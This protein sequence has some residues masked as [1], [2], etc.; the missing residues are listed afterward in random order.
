MKQRYKPE[1]PDIKA[2]ERL[3]RDLQV[4]ADEEAKQAKLNPNK[5]VAPSELAR[6][7]AFAI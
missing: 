7:S 4:K 3:I 5:A 2:A 6:Q 1:H